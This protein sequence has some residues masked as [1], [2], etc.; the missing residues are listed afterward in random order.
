MKPDEE[1]KE[2]PDKAELV[3]GDVIGDTAYSERFVL[4]ILLKLAN[5]DTLKHEIPEKSFEDDLCTLWDMTTERDVVLF[6][7]KHDVLN[8]INFA[9][10]V[11]NSPRIIEIF[12]GIVGNM[13]CQTEAVIE[14]LK[15]DGLMNTLL[16]YTKSD[17]SL[18]L[19]QLLRLIS[20]CLF[21][22]QDDDTALWMKLFLNYGYSD[23]LYFILNNSS[24]KD[25]LVAALENFNTVCSYCNI[26]KH[27]KD[28]FIHFITDEALAS[29]C[30]AFTE[31]TINQKELLDTDALERLLLISLQIVLNLT[32]FE[33]SPEIYANKKENLITMICHI[34]NY[35]ENKFVKQKEID[36]DIVDIIE[37]TNTVVNILKLGEH[38]HPNKFF[39]QTH[40][41]WQAACSMSNSNNCSDFEDDK[42]ELLEFP[43]KV[44]GPLATLM[45]LY[46]SQCDQKY[47][48]KVLDIMRS[49]H[50]DIL[51]LIKDVDLQSAVTKR[52]DD[53]RTR[54]KEN[55]DS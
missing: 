2:K 21:L 12:I 1:I 55:V 27:R 36:S 6:L 24:N 46:V 44:K 51:K 31:V 41:M 10:P 5:L 17:D 47:L 33:K 30:S 42:K 34:M 18:I 40:K 4:K 11:V 28:F 39:T 32:G 52:T 15:M 45:G 37:S 48:L 35:Y 8:L 14:L 43:E 25:L 38:S 20:S 22:S 26:D 16:E 19:I 54:L 13:C 49:D 53:Y 50:E 9:L 29:L 23:A 7:Q 3:A